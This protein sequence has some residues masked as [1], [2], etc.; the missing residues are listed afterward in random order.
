MLLFV[1]A[2]LFYRL[3]CLWWPSGSNTERRIKKCVETEAT[4]NQHLKGRVM[5]RES[6]MTPVIL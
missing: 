4:F 6:D 1:K 3:M 2:M 5:K